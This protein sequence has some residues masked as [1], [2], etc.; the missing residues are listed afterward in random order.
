MLSTFVPTSPSPLLPSPLKGPQITIKAPS[1]H[2]TTVGS[3]IVLECLFSSGSAPATSV[4]WLL[5]GQPVTEANLDNV[6]L[7]GWGGGGGGIIRQT[8]ISIQ[9]SAIF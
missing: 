1:P 5:D 3:D 2:D 6:H 8:I 9:V 4:T 7:V